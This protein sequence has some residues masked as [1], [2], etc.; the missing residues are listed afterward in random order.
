MRAIPVDVRLQLRLVRR[1]SG[2]LE[3]TGYCTKEGYGRIWSAP[4]MVQTHRLAWE[5]AHGPIP[6][7]LKVL[8]HC[9][10][11]PCCEPYG[12]DHLFLGTDADNTA[13][14]TAKGRCFNQKKT[15]CPQNHRY[16]A[17]NTYI[18]V[19]KAGLRHRQCKACTIDR[20]MARGPRTTRLSRRR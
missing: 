18:I 13:D 6:L 19:D 11:P 4:S 5:L 15:H 1:P 16:T 10:N 2:C 9:D 20:D 12:L 3:W 7:G 14:R 8:H 17:A